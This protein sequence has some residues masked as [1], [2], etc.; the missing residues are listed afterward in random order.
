MNNVKLFGMSFFLSHTTCASHRSHILIMSWNGASVAN[1][2]QSNMY[3]CFGTIQW[4]SVHSFESSVMV[5][6]LNNF[7]IRCKSQDT[8]ISLEVHQAM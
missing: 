3:S 7:V 8:A 6:I 2:K 4:L 5:R 1:E